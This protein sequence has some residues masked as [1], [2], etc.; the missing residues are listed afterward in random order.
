MED[1]RG[2]RAVPTGH[3]LAVPGT[4]FLRLLQ[5]QLLSRVPDQKASRAPTPSD[6][7][8]IPISFVDVDAAHEVWRRTQAVRISVFGNGQKLRLVG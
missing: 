5:L 4:F 3:G 6:E 2:A 1:A 8:L 7:L